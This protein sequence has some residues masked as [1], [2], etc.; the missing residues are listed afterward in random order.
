MVQVDLPAAFVIGQIYAMLAKGY[1][2]GTK[3]IH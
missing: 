2:K 1:L 3:K